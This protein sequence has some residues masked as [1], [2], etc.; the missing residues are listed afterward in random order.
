MQRILKE[1]KK[2]ENILPE[3]VIVSVVSDQSIF[4][5]SAIQGVTSAAIQG[6]IL[7]LLVLLFFLRNVRS[8]VIVAFAIPVSVMAAFSLMYFSGISINMISLGGLA[9][10]IGMLVDN[11]I[12]VVENI[13]RNRQI[14]KG[15]KDAAIVGAEEM[16]SA[17]TAST[18]TTV[19]I[20]LPMVFVIGVAGQLF[21][22]LAF[23]ITF[24]L[25]ASLF[26]ALSLLPRL[27]M[28]GEGRDITHIKII[29][30]TDRWL[31]H[32]AETYARV[33]KNFLANRK[34][35]LFII[36]CVFI[37]SLVLFLVVGK[38][39]MPK[40]DEG[41]FM[42]KVDMP[43]GTKLDIT[44]GI[45]K[46][47]EEKILDM[48]YVKRVNAIVGSS[49][50]GSS[51]SGNIEMLKDNQAQIVVN[52][53]E[54]R[55][56]TTDRFIQKLKKELELIDIEDAEIKFVLSQSAFQSAFQGEGAPVIIEV[57]GQNLDELMRISRS[58]MNGL[59]KIKGIYDVK[60]SMEEPAPETKIVVNKNKAA[61]YNLSVRDIARTVQIA[62]DGWVATKFKEE[63]KEIDIR[64]RLEE[65]DRKDFSAIKQMRIISPDGRE[66]SLEE[67]TEFKLGTGP[68]EIKRVDKERTILVYANV[69]GRNINEIVGEISN[70]ID[71]MELPS[72]YRKPKLTG[73]REQMR[74]SFNSLQFALILAILLVYMIMA[75]QFESLW[76]PF[77]IM[78][79]VPLSLIGVALALFITRT[80][81]NVVAILGIIMLG[82][83]VVNNGIVLIDY[84]NA[85]TKKGKKTFDAVIEAANTRL[86]PILMTTLTTVVGLLPLAI[87]GGI[88]SPLAITVMG[89]LLASAFL[90]LV[91]IPSVYLIISEFLSKGQ[92]GQV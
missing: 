72:G 38:E 3:R 54:R 43:P 26:V 45:S 70:F 74:E 87:A 5:K 78:F 35:G 44:N 34:K 24:S 27:A 40:V 30:R 61:L 18:L 71:G 73:E 23:T 14:G 21:K 20:F 12:V 7:A 10:G 11:A 52:L 37:A 60:S 15:L 36:F 50:E 63:G 6:G 62:I 79:T 84:I 59:S 2:I 57:K 86:R 49:K 13:F 4:T 66:V 33:L 51:V 32:L 42:I 77:V 31:K 89:G 58:V 8:S 68:S 19:A 41:Q 85:L 69:F 76:Q 91:V 16:N 55:R 81:L 29:V 92:R 17:I 53:E 83:I 88:M 9:L 25:L 67:V 56:L 82:G 46:R 47:I 39:F 80:T 28:S 90:T 75:A 22:Q 1:L 65:E 48:K 64:V